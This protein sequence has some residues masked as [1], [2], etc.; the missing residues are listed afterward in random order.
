MGPDISGVSPVMGVKGCNKM[1]LIFLLIYFLPRLAYCQHFMALELLLGRKSFFRLWSCT[2]TW[3]S[4][5]FQMET[6]GMKIIG[7]RLGK[8][9]RPVPYTDEALFVNDPS[10]DA[11]KTLARSG[12]DGIMQRSIS[13]MRWNTEPVSPYVP[14]FV[15][16]R[17]FSDVDS[18]LRQKICASIV[19]VINEWPKAQFVFFT[20][21][22]WVRFPMGVEWALNSFVA[23]T[24]ITGELE[25]I[26]MAHKQTYIFTNPY[27]QMQY[28]KPR[29]LPELDVLMPHF[30]IQTLATSFVIPST[31]EHI[32]H[33]TS[34]DLTKY[35]SAAY[36]RHFPKALLPSQ[37]YPPVPVFATSFFG[38]NELSLPRLAMTKSC[39]SP[40]NREGTTCK[41]PCYPKGYRR[42]CNL[43]TDGHPL[44]QMAN[45]CDEYNPAVKQLE[46]NRKLCEDI[47]MSPSVPINTRLKIEG[48]EVVE[49]TGG[50]DE[51]VER[52]ASTLS[53]EVPNNQEAYSVGPN[54]IAELG[55]ILGPVPSPVYDSALNN[56]FMDVEDR[57]TNSVSSEYLEKFARQICEEFVL[58][59][60]VLEGPNG[61]RIH[62]LSDHYTNKDRCSILAVHVAIHRAFGVNA[63][64]GHEIILKLDETESNAP[65]YSRSC[66][67]SMGHVFTEVMSENFLDVAFSSGPEHYRPDFRTNTTST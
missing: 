22:Q 63:N 38:I 8:S 7:E 58:V 2:A 10:W 32:E 42:R 6:K 16:S 60:D 31:P 20:T 9:V 48:C 28:F 44:Q 57:S 59:D 53:M 65:L 54:N 50:F 64:S 33:V 17:V 11:L 43:P 18:N 13:A 25:K 56:S 21:P 15:T 52:L 36:V 26:S 45:W 1:G 5:R 19:E 23:G 66:L 3:S 61:R 55:G 4:G 37:K 47:G 30:M 27:Y 39:R 24:L 14:V 46:R 34:F 12:L 35:P 49:G 51:C 62:H 67:G 29:P 40:E 41:N